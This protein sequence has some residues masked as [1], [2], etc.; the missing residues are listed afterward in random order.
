MNIIIQLTRIALFYGM[1]LLL[2]L[3]AL[4][5]PDSAS[6]ATRPADVK[7]QSLFDGKTLGKWVSTNFGGEGE[8]HVEDG[9]IFLDPGVSL[10]GVNY[11]GDVPKMNYEV[12]LDAQ[13]V[14]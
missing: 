14:D 10:T 11:T 3:C 8:V 6:P 4:A 13:R 12:A 2:P 1:M 5:A 7:W 9:A